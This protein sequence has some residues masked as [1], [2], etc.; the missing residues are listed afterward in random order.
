MQLG[1][2]KLV[3]QLAIPGLNIINAGPGPATEVLCLMNMVTAEELKDNDEYED[4]LEDIREECT[5][6][7]AV[8][9]V[10]IPRPIEGLDV[11]GVGKVF[12]EFSNVAECQRAQQG[13]TGRKFANRVV[14]TSYFDPDLYHR[15]QF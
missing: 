2:K 7:G 13:L 3:V 9:S 14:V 1:D 5:K 8:K 15:R 10:E 11:P 12:V 6:Y 4:I